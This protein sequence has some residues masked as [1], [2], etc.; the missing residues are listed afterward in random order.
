MKPWTKLVATLVAAAA[1]TAGGS[2]P[3]LSAEPTPAP[4]W[5]VD[6]LPL[7]THFIPGDSSGTASYQIIVSSI[8]GA[9]TD[10]SPIT[11]TDTLPAGLTT[12]GAPE[13][14]LRFGNNSEEKKD[15]GPSVCQQ[16]KPAQSVIVT[17]TVPTEYASPTGDEPS[18]LGPGESLNL[19]IPVSV[20][21]GITEG[22]SLVNQVQVQGGGAATASTNS[23]NLASATPAPRGLSFFRAT[24]TDAAG[25]PV[26]QAGA[27]L[28]QY[29]ISFALNTKKSQPGALA[30]FIPSGG[31]AK[32]LR[33]K[34][35]PGLVADAVHSPRCTARQFD[36][37]RSL[38][39]INPVFGTNHDYEVN[40]CPDASALGL[41]SFRLNGTRGE[42]TVALY[43][44][45]PPPG[46]PAQLGFFVPTSP[47]STYIDTEVS[48]EDG[49]RITGTVHNASQIQRI[50]AANV[51]IWGNPAATAHDPMRGRCSTPYVYYSIDPGLPCP[52]G[53]AE[54]SLWR[55]PTSCGRALETTMD[56]NTW[57]EPESFVSATSVGPVIEG[58]DQVP[59]DPTFA[60]QPDTQV[61]DS[62][63]G[64]EVDLHIPQPA[65][66]EGL[67]ESDLRDTSVQLPSGLV[68]NPSGANGLHACSED[69][70][71][72]EGIVSD[73]Q[74]FSNAPAA[75]PSAAKIGSVEVDTPLLDHSLKGGIYV[76]S[77]RANPFGSLLALY[78]AV[79][80][81]ETGVVL[82]L[83]GEVEADAGTGQLTTSFDHTPQLP[84]EDFKL[85]FFGGPSA[86]LRTPQT[87]GNHTV[88]SSLTPWSAPGSGPPATRVAEFAISSVFGG[89]PCVESGSELPNAPAFQ[90]G[91]ETPLAGS[92]SPIVINLD[93]DDGSQE[94]S[95]LTISAPPGLL[96]RLAGVAYC[97]ESAIA[98]AAGKAGS[99]EAMSPTCP[100]AS[101]VGSVAVA[102]GAGPAPFQTEG[103]VYLAGPYKGAP[104]SLAIVTP[105][106]AGPYDLGT[107]IVRVALLVDPETAQIT[108]VS[109]PIPHILQGIPLDVRSISIRLDR[110]GWGLN[111]TD[112]SAFAFRGTA[113]SVF[114]QSADLMHGFQA[115]GCDRL[116]FKPKLRI[117]LKGST[118]RNRFPALKAVLTYPKKGIYAN[119]ARA[120]VGLPHSEFLEQDHIG[121]TCTRP[122]L[123]AAHCPAA[124]IYGRA[125]A[126]SPLL[127][128]PLE[129]PVYLGVGFGHALPDLVADLDGQIRILLHSRIDTTKQNGIRSTFE[130]VPDAPVS[131]FVLEMKGGKK[132]LLVNS[133]NLCLKAQRANARFVAH[134]GRQVTLRPVIDNGC[135][136]K[137]HLKRG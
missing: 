31:D 27:D 64:L 105:A 96:A 35:P 15:F 110:S 75:C 67:S 25:Q 46:M 57:S 51:T 28:Y 38:T 107:V 87:C 10:G 116:A 40:E 41:A 45:V 117:G 13:L 66:L 115:G 78:I 73:V 102:A 119:I 90:A 5:A 42:L 89:G 125:K 128:K 80:D 118:K 44:L 23:E 29:R 109:D 69:Q 112:C 113:V 2:T 62:P 1:L 135:K 71:G 47:V 53:T 121:S 95:Q 26:A 32:D 19:T 132:G 55:L 83:A 92:S 86:A 82:K 127:D 124:S 108:A 48:P 134:N 54:Q 50:T 3:A 4:A 65:G 120:Q 11:I 137:R 21:V 52:A 17:C 6:S 22:S 58:C 94:L 79:H 7:P 49:Y 24:A 133:E 76:A 93:R 56:V 30:P 77:P 103:T 61:A 130:V 12:V 70:V 8:G 34:L 39:F 98:A 59:F 123:A 16:Q 99:D 88:S 74:Q 81:P 36:T 100:S 91:T 129:G 136:P 97:P 126:W 106:V 85:R 111:P 14:K 18:R 104:L 43:N 68:V 114:D 101:R 9:F 131:R 84:F 63:T 122:Q 20:P 37:R 60:L 72:Y 33:T